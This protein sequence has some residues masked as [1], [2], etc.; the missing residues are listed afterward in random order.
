M[1]DSKVACIFEGTTG[2]QAMDFT[3]RKVRQQKGAVFAQFMEDMNPVIAKASEHSELKKYAGQ[4]ENAK[5]AL[6]TVPGLFEGQMKEGRIYYPYLNAT[7]FLDAAGDVIVAWFLL[8]SAVV[9]SDKL[10]RLFQKNKIE[11]N[12]QQKSY[13]QKNAEAAF[14]DGKIQS[15]KFFIGN[16]LPVTDGKIAAMK[17]MDA[18]AWDI[19]EKSFG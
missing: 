10:G 7:P 17:W 16:I 4:L 12:E 5:N 13:V 9:A 19:C 14:L 1:R 6:L 2:I 15:A 18:S 11:G 3:F 8:W